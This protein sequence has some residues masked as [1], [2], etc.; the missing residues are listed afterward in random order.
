[1]PILKTA[2]TFPPALKKGGTIGIVSPASAPDPAWI[3]KGTSLLQKRGYRVVVH[4]QNSL[5]QGVL[6]GSDQARADALRD[7][8]ADPSIDAVMCSRGG[9]GAIRMIDKVD[10]KLISKN[11]KP[12]IGFSDI[13]LLLQAITR[14]CG[15]VTYHG[16]TMW[17]LAHKRDPR[18][19]DDL[20]AV[21]GN[22]KR[23]YKF[24]S[25][26]AETIRGGKAEG[27]LVG[28]NIALLQSLIN[29]PYDWSAKDAILFIEDVSEPLYK[30]DRMLR[31]MRLAGK[32]EGVRAVIV[33]EM[34]GLRDGKTDNEP[35]GQRD[36]GR[37]FVD[38]LT[39]VLPPDIPL[40]LNFPCGHGKY[41]TTLPVG[42]HVRLA[43]GARGA[44]LGF[45]MV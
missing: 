36:Y 6:A 25:T 44:T 13:T 29:T 30:L 40:C 3:A 26:E 28:G 31:H 19:E 21:I 24:V 33:G 7:M 8:F 23:N 16:P 14:R 38:V 41:I 4:S 5:R 32:F 43:L 11:P 39:E 22:S 17:N 37:H 2:A 34:V 10:Y 15:F 12:F 1:M 18:V 27:R 35:V 42:A 9:N 20:F 45:E